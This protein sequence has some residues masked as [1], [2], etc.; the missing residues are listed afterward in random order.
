MA[1]RRL[2][3]LGPELEAGGP[4]KR[5]I[6]SAGQLTGKRIGTVKGTSARHFL[7]SFL[8]FNGVDP[9]KVDRFWLP[10]E[11]IEAALKAGRIDAAAIWEPFAYQSPQ[12]LA[13][14]G[15]VLPSKRVYTKSFN[16]IASHK[17]IA[18]REANPVQAAGSSGCVQ[19]K[20]H[21]RQGATTV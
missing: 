14:D 10:P 16:L 11:Q 18:E 20:L 3:D 13:G 1:I 21:A 12:A 8:L 4:Q 2:R 17:L 15:L 6:D 7:D 9:K 19:C 5:G